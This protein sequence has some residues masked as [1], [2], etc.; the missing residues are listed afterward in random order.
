MPRSSLAVTDSVHS[1][2]AQNCE[3]GALDLYG[4]DGWLIERV[5]LVGDHHSLSI[6]LAHIVPR[7]LAS[8]CKTIVLHHCHPSGIARPSEADIVATRAF[9]GLLRLLGMRLHDHIICGGGNCF[10]FRAQGLI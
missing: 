6:D 8:R 9:A 3:L 10:S 4:A 2:A 7:L 5:D 1:L